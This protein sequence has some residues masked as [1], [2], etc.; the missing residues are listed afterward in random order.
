MADTKTFNARILRIEQTQYGPKAVLSTKNYPEWKPINIKSD[1]DFGQWKMGEEYSVTTGKNEAG[2]G[3]LL[4]VGPPK[5]WSG[6]G[7]SGGGGWSKPYDP[8][9]FCSNVV[10]SAITAK[11]I[12]KPEELEAWFKEAHRLITSVTGGSVTDQK[13]DI[14][15][16]YEQAIDLMKQVGRLK[17]WDEDA[18]TIDKNYL[19]AALTDNKR[20]LIKERI[21]HY[22]SQIH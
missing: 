5:Q 2:Y 8:L 21:A 18:F 13:E 15:K 17:E 7:R 19:D 9:T 1:L 11:T 16:M 6:G 4:A 3:I 14:M 10:G 20:D 12:T 22:R